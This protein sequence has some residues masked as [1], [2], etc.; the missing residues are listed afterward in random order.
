MKFT[1]LVGPWTNLFQE[2]QLLTKAQVKRQ[3]SFLLQPFEY[4]IE[5]CH[6]RPLSGASL[7]AVGPKCHE[8][9]VDGVRGDQAANLSHLEPFSEYNVTIVG[10]INPLKRTRSTSL[11]A[12]TRKSSRSSS[13][14]SSVKM[15]SYNLKCR[16][17]LSG[18]SWHK[19]EWNQKWHWMAL[20]F[21]SILIRE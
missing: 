1:I 8:L 18:I 9:T 20:S 15:N 21:F 5:Y 17:S 6:I 13:T 10:T 2:E 3:L 12:R 19:D 14:L 7:P 4:S 11:I 16:F